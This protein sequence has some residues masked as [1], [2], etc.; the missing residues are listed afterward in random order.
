MAKH[1]CVLILIVAVAVDLGLRNGIINVSSDLFRS[2][3]FLLTYAL[4]SVIAYME[5]RHGVGTSA[6]LFTFW[7][8]HL[9]SSL[10]DFKQD[11]EALLAKVEAEV[12]VRAIMWFPMI[13]VQFVLHCWSDHEDHGRGEDHPPENYASC[14]SHL[15]FSW[16]DSTIWKGFRA[17]LTQSQLSR[18][19]DHVDVTRNVGEFLSKWHPSK[20]LW[21]VL[22]KTYGCRVALVT[23][24]GLL[25]FVAVFLNP[26]LLKLLIGYVEEDSDEE[27]WKGYAYT[28]LLFASFTVSTLSFHVFLHQ[29]VIVG[30]RMRT[31]LVSAIYR[32]SLRLSNQARKQYTTGEITNYMSVDAQHV[33][34]TIPFL[35][36]LWS[37]P[38]Q[39]ILSLYFL[40]RELGPSTF[41]GL[42]VLL[43][44]T[45]INVWTSKKAESLEEQQLAAKDTRI[46]LLSEMLSGMKVLKLYAWEAP[47]GKRV[48]DIRAKEVGLLGYAAKLWALTNFTFAASPFFVTLAVFAI[49]VAIDPV[50]NVLDAQKIFV[51]ISLF[52]IMRLP[53]TMFP[54]AMVEAIKMVVSVN[55]IARFLVAEELDP[56]GVGGQ[57]QD[58]QH[59]VEMDQASV[60]WTSEAVALSDLNV[61][62]PRGALVAVVGPVGSGKSSLISAILGDMDVSAGSINVQADQRVAYV[63]QQAWIQNR[64]LKNNILFDKP[65]SEQEY[66]RVVKACALVPDLDMLTAGDAT[67]IGENGINLSGGQKQRVSI[68]RA[69]Y[70]DAD[71]YLL[72]DPLSA[73][74]A[75]VGKHIFEQVIS[76]KSGLLKHKTRIMATNSIN[77]LSHVDHIVVMRDGTVGEQGSYEELV[78]TQGPF[79]EFLE[80]YQDTFVE[81]G[82]PSMQRRSMSVE[83][84]RGVPISLQR[85]VSVDEPHY[86]T[87]P[88]A[89]RMRLLSATSIHEEDLPMPHQE[90]AVQGDDIRTDGAGGNLVE[91][92]ASMTGRVKWSVYWQYVKS[93]GPGTSAIVIC[94]YLLGQSLHTGSNIWLA[95]WSDN[96]ANNPASVFLAVYAGLGG[97][98]ALVELVR[99]FLLFTSCVRAA[100]VIHERLLKAILHSPMSFFDT[101]PMGR[102][103]NRFSGDIDT[104]DQTIPFQMS[105][106]LWCACDAVSVVVVISYSTPVFISV[107][108]PLSIVYFLLQKY[109]IATSRQL[110]RLN[111]VSKSP[112][113]S[114]FGETVTG[115]STVRAFGQ[116]DRFILDSESLMDANVR[117]AYYSYSSNRWLGIRIE[118]LGNLVVFFAALFAI[119]ARHNLSGGT[120]GLS[121]SYA[122]QITDTLNWMIRMVC[123]LET[124]CVSVERVLDYADNNPQEADWERKDVQLPD[125]WPDS[126][127]IT[128]DNYQT[129]YRPGLDLVLKGVD[130]EVKAGEK[131][132]ICGR[133]GAGK[134]SLTLA[135]FRLIEPAGGNIFIDNFDICNTG[136]HQL[137][138]KLTIIP[139]DPVLFTGDV[140][141]NLDPTGDHSD[142]ELWTALEHAHLKEHVGQLSGGLDHE[143]SE[144]GVNFSVGQRQL[145][146]LAR[147]LLRKSKIL[148]L[149]EATAAIDVETDDLIQKTIRRE[150]SG[151]TVLTIAHRLNTIMDSDRVALL[152]DGKLLE[153]D[154]PGNL[155]KQSR[156][157][158][159]AMASDVHLAK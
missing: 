106:F 16:M 142:E 152:S 73:V 103:I 75:H 67:E 80:Q 95:Y 36:N 53:L 72:D 100:K 71:L 84:P 34:E 83:E 5:K 61:K 41:G 97:S 11:I 87:P 68:A 136:V 21:F 31:A 107:I 93:I 139:Q 133:T 115:A 70:A 118:S 23:V 54:W 51:S 141:F 3:A 82:K 104:I 17:P 121:I 33:V 32:K 90:V 46:K 124:N 154:A 129:R 128:F 81:A 74:D 64:S 145:V 108:V 37:A 22:L 26:Q 20:S 50:H 134:S 39:V 151:C 38:L 110:K 109:Y 122:M 131:V 7:F 56:D 130:M 14:L 47:F 132:G 158:F 52:N 4:S 35:S 27:T 105:D 18:C 140:R 29:T 9:F 126:G 55:R 114:H 125:N 156:S 123:D 150:F 101:N 137:R 59:V 63:T 148:V 89:S 88:K 1:L 86:G 116:T 119:L 66:K 77:I 45:P 117:C 157:A 44:M 24:I 144:A 8:V 102:I 155:L 15:L 30:L 153:Y 12:L 127:G 10:P 6:L 79:A 94:M 146:C 85:S 57:V 28:V 111:S 135:L 43:A 69:V 13:L 2:F 60:S 76:S 48:G 19:P 92:E 65:Y 40:Y 58:Q 147:A 159:K 78:A 96:K 120:A 113:F 25:H 143:V 49:Y 138:S 99:E 91:D 98:E 112:V 149:D 62:V 42:A